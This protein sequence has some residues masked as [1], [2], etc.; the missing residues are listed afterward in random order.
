MLDLH[1][2]STASDGRLRPKELVRQARA[3]GLRGLALTDH[4]TTAGVAEAVLAGLEVGLH[5]IPGVEI[6]AEWNEEDVHILGYWTGNRGKLP[7]IMEKARTAREERVKKITRRLSELGV[8]LTFD[9]VVAANSGRFEALGR[10]HVARALMSKGLVSSVGEAFDKYLER[11]RQAFVPRFK[12]EPEEAIR[13][14]ID[15]GGV[16]VWAHPG[17]LAHALIR[18]LIQAGLKGLEVFHPAHSA[19]TEVALLALAREHH[20]VVTGGSDAHEAI[21]IGNKYCPLETW[22]AL[23]RER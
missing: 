1:T 15:S 19:E 17:Q 4:D 8:A 7:S 14:I 18:P 2:H 16:P 3:I 5:V 13:A 12:L 10:P 11:G 6:S 21:N 9:E 22:S 20:L 23:W